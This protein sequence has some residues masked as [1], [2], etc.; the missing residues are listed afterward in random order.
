MIIRVV[1]LFL[2]V[3]VGPCLIL[4]LIYK[5]NM[6]K[7][8][9]SLKVTGPKA[10]PYRV[11]LRDAGIASR[12]DVFI[13]SDRMIVVY[14]LKNI[15]MPYSEISRIEETTGSKLPLLKMLGVFGP[16]LVIT[17]RKKKYNFDFATTGIDSMKD[18]L[19]EIPELKGKLTF[20]PRN[21]SLA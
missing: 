7:A 17:F 20:L 1:Y 15:D 19:L 4:Y 6:K 2:V 16:R 12:I 8:E 21:Q 14:G 3:V 13:D 11:L 10:G 18:R 5:W 9:R